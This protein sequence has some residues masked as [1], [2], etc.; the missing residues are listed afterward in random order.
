LILSDELF[1]LRASSIKSLLASFRAEPEFF[2]ADKSHV[3]DAHEAQKRLEMRLLRIGCAGRAL[4]VIATAAFD[5]DRAFAFEQPDG[6]GLGVAERDA[7]SQHVVKLGL[8]RGRDAEVIHR[9]T[10]Y[11]G[12]GRFQ[13]RDQR[14]RQRQH[15]SLRLV[16]GRGA[17]QRGG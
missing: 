15:G 17:A 16:R 14:I 6:T 7:R 1:E 2:C 5:D 11:D 9:R 10:N 8:E 13:L 4:A 12:V 3:P